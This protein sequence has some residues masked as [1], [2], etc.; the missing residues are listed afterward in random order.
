MIALGVLAL[1]IVIVGVIFSPW[2]D[3]SMKAAMSLF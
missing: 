2:Y 3:V 1:G